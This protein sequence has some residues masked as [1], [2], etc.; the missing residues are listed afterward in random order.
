MIH[1]EKDFNQVPEFLKTEKINK[2]IESLA[3]YPHKGG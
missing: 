2:Y 1:V 3:N